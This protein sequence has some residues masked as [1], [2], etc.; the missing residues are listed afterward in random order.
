MDCGQ[1]AKTKVENALFSILSG[2]IV[3]WSDFKFFWNFKNCHL[4]MDS[5][6]NS[7]TIVEKAFF[8]ILRNYR[9]NHILQKTANFWTLPFF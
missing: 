2:C 4:K 5:G 6:F 1:N 3:G 8:D 9:A 7:K